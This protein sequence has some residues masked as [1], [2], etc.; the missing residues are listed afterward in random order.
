MIRNILSNALKYTK[1]GK[2]LLGIR[3]Q[4]THIR[5]EIWDSGLGIPESELQ[6]IFEEYH[7][8]G[9]SAR[10][11]ANGLGLGLAIVKRL[12]DMLGHRVSVCSRLGKGSVFA[13]E[14]RASEPGR[15]YPVKPLW[16][17]DAS[18]LPAST[19]V[20]GTILLIEDAPDIRL[21]LEALLFTEGYQIATASDGIEAIDMITRNLVR[22]DLILAD[23]NLPNGMNGLQLAA[24]ARHLMHRALPVI[25]LSGDISA[26]TLATIAS[27]RCVQLAKPVKLNELRRVVQEQ[28]L[29]GQSKSANH[30]HVLP[31]SAQP[32]QPVVYI[33]DDD[34]G[35]RRALGDVLQAEGLEV[36]DFPSSESF[37]AAFRPGREA[38]LLIDATLPGMSGLDLLR[39]LAANG[40]H[41]PSVMI[42]GNGDIAIAVEAMKAGA[43]DFIEKPV[44][45]KTLLASTERALNLARHGR[46]R[47]EERD[48]AISQLAG[49][50]PRQHQIMDM[51]LAGHPNKN[52]AADLGI[53][54]RTVENHRAAI[55]KRTGSASL[56]DLARVAVAAEPKK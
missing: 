8:I 40:H 32:S 28:I 53:S 23:F 9:N 48:L 3:R 46:Q 10:E 14:A 29:L 47:D 6:S 45:A 42:T 33:V 20:S 52:I 18:A 38:C 34:D 12:G 2:I 51:I 54:Q 26:E 55:M 30:M 22:P 19:V 50:T 43:T 17:A 37:I 36:E 25:I 39:Y 5:I 56:P 13:I 15:S 16:T 21:L 44:S 24:K 31:P 35:L 49:L 11:R 4:G 27:E 7:Q 1:V 41:L